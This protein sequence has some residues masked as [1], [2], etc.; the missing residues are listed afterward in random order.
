MKA[1]TTGQKISLLV[2]ERRSD[3]TSAGSTSALWTAT[4]TSWHQLSTTYVAKEGGNA[5]TY[6]VT[7]SNL[8]GSTDAILADSFRLTSG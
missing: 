3:G 8:A 4:D 2:K 7:V 5:L 6:S 1:S